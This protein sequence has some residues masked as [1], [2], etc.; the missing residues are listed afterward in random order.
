[1]VVLADTNLNT[2]E[3]PKQR[4]WTWHASVLVAAGLAG[5]VVGVAIRPLIHDGDSAGASSAASPMAWASSS[6]APS[7]LP[8]VPSL[9]MPD[10]LKRSYGVGP[11]EED[12]MYST[13]AGYSLRRVHYDSDGLRIYALE[14]VPTTEP[15]L[16]GYPAVVIAH[17]FEDP[18]HYD[19]RA[20]NFSAFV[21]DYTHR[22]F[23]VL[24]PDYRG[25]GQSQGKAES[26][27]FSSGYAVDVLNLLADLKHQHDVD[28]GALGVVGYSLG[29]NVVLKAVA[30]DPDVKAAVLLAGAT[31]QISEISASALPSEQSGLVDHAARETLVA[32]HG[33]PRDDVDFWRQMAPVNYLANIGASVSL[34]HC[35]DDPVVPAKFSDE[36]Y[37]KL[38]AAGK[39]AS[40]YRCQVGGHG[41]GGASN[42]VGETGAFL[43]SKLNH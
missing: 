38:L 35:A 10:L 2:E 23:M 27:Y 5:V 26:A 4:H 19:T 25:H 40:Y 7:A 9:T 42:L 32:E 30:V 24:V 15:P 11:I 29:G 3:P 1:M 34:Y 43:A 41:F 18:A 28:P 37:D 21:A 6:P 14:A 33:Q 39:Q 13:Q 8:A 36:L 22:G 31:G 20:N 16:R 12:E 17:G